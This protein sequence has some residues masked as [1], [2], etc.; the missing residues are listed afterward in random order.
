MTDFRKIAVK[1]GKSPAT[2]A[3]PREQDEDYLD[4]EQILVRY[5]TVTTLCFAAVCAIVVILVAS[6][7]LALLFSLSKT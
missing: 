2:F 5:P 3:M 4:I 7:L 1:L 6:T